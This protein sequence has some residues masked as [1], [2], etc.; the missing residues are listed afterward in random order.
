VTSRSSHG[1]E[2]AC[3]ADRAPNL[4]DVYDE[5]VR[6]SF[7]NRLPIGWTGER[8]GPLTRCLTNDGGFAMLTHPPLAVPV[9]ELRALV[10]RTVEFFQRA[11]RW[12]EWK[13]FDHDPAPLRS[14]LLDAGAVPESREW[15]VLGPAEELVGDASLP[16]GLTMRQVTAR[17]DLER[18]A[19]LESTIW[20]TDWSWLAEDLA[21]RLDADP[22]TTVLVVEDGDVMVSAAWLVPLR[23]TSVAGLWGGSTLAGYRRR[24]I[25]RALVAERARIAV[26]SGYRTLQVDASDDSRPIL[27][28]LGLSAVGSTTPYII[29]R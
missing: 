5:Q 26:A 22:P 7:P 15:L 23:G 25:Y 20:N 1:D 28:R 10:H 16:R 21:S 13:T 17:P 14:L 2:S 11:G 4:L 9:D 27:E 18:V 12:F 6:R 24:G 8:D 19:E 3:G 29:G